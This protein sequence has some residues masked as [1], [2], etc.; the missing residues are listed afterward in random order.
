MPQNA[1]QRP[2]PNEPQGLC[3]LL[4]IACVSASTRRRVKPPDVRRRVAPGAPR[5]SVKGAPDTKKDHCGFRILPNDNV[6]MAAAEVYH[7]TKEIGA[8]N[9][10]VMIDWV[11]ASSWTMSPR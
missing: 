11:S 6:S 10:A 5:W 8:Y 3:V 4:C 2:E 7:A 1:N 9:H